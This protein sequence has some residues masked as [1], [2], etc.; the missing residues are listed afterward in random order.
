MQGH[1]K[2]TEKKN[3]KKYH[4][5][6][7]YL[8]DIVC[9]LRRCLQEHK[10]IFFCK[11]VTLLGR[12][13]AAVVEITLIS[14]EHDDHVGVSILSCLFQ[15]AC[16]MVECFPSCYIIDQEGT[17][18][19]AVIRSGD[20]TKRFLPGSVPDLQLDVFVVNRNHARTKL[21][22]DSQVVDRLKSLVRKLQEKARLADTCVANDDV[23][24]KV[25][26]G[27]RIC[28]WNVRRIIVAGGVGS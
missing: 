10:V 25:G 11:T 13:S 26:V 28:G 23:F 20:A 17:S 5:E 9:T 8:L 14:N 22:T 16:Q 1:H 2:S 21:N 18:R 3:R 15:P 27:H 19:A 6:T 12:D 7:T 4:V 24:E